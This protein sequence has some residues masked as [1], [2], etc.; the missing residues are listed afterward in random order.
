[1]GTLVAEM[2]DVCSRLQLQAITIHPR[3]GT[4]GKSLGV[5]GWVTGVQSIESLVL[6]RPAEDSRVS[7]GQEVGVSQQTELLN[8]FA[9]YRLL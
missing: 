6:T 1:M 9:G 2:W 4:V 3:S 7:T 8:T 5:G